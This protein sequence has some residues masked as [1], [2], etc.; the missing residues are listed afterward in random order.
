MNKIKEYLKNFKLDINQNR[1][2]FKY[3][4]FTHLEFFC[5]CIDIF[6]KFYIKTENTF[7]IGFGI[8]KNEYN[9]DFCFISQTFDAKKS[10]IDALKIFI[11][12]ILINNYEITIRYQENKE[13]FIL[14]ILE[15]LFNY[16]DLVLHNIRFPFVEFIK[17]NNNINEWISLVDQIKKL[18]NFKNLI[19]PRIAIY[20]KICNNEVLFYILCLKNLNVNNIY[21]QYNINEVFISFTAKVLFKRNDKKMVI[22]V[23][24][25]NINIYDSIEG[26]N[27]D[28]HKNKNDIII[29]S[30]DKICDNIISGSIHIKESYYIKYLHNKIFSDTKTINDIDIIDTLNPSII[31]CGNPLNETYK[32]LRNNESIYRNYYSAPIGIISNNHSI[33]FLG[34]NSL[35]IKKDIIELYSECDI[36]SKND[37]YALWEELNNN[38]LFF[39]YAI[40]STTIFSKTVNDI[41]YLWTEIIF[42]ELFKLGICTVFIT[43]EYYNSPLI[44]TAKKYFKNIFYGINTNTTNAL[45]YGYCLSNNS[46]N[47][48]NNAIIITDILSSNFFEF[49]NLALKNKINLLVLTEINTATIN[50]SVP[51][52]YIDFSLINQENIPI[53]LSQLDYNLMMKE[54]VCFNFNLSKFNYNNIKYIPRKW[55]TNYLPYNQYI[56]DINHLYK[57]LENTNCLIIIGNTTYHNII[58][59]FKTY[60]VIVDISSKYFLNSLN[61]I[62]FTE[63]FINSNIHKYYDTIII[64]GDNLSKSLSDFVNYSD[65]ELIYISNTYNLTNFI[66]PTK[67][68]IL[69]NITNIPLCKNNLRNLLIENEH[70]CL[71]YYKNNI[72]FLLSQII[73]PNHILYLDDVTINNYFFK[74][75]YYM[76]VGPIVKSNLNI[77]KDN[78][79]NVIIGES[80]YHNNPITLIINDSNIFNNLDNILLLKQINIQLAI[81]IL[82]TKDIQINIINTFIDEGIYFHSTDK[83]TDLSSYYKQYLYHKKILIIEYKLNNLDSL[84]M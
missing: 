20:K 5:N 52:K 51:F 13:T 53:M 41:N 37:P 33:V 61:V 64:I 10:T 15:K 29:E 58:A 11:P 76:N 6:P 63:D 67:Q 62:Y 9:N 23:I 18:N 70:I 22:D 49:Y 17:Y 27:K 65:I 73:I 59:E 68:F 44:H 36:F 60:S 78:L 24:T 35:F 31:N 69:N 25:G 19:I 66:K 14:N 77:N 3:S 46:F 38:E 1:I 4:K 82:N 57:I 21:F 43:P 26:L 16:T 42:L 7:F 8:F 28:L 40:S 72:Y 12:N 30:I 80:L 75:S 79:L 81:I 2:K 83:F 56:Y 71:N 45:Y 74:Y 34:L 50:H 32:W 48:I 84:N 39:K 55:L 54:P 47:H